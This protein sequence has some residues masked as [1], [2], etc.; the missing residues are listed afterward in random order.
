[1]Q[2]RVRKGKSAAS[3]MSR[4]SAVNSRQYTVNTELHTVVYKQK[5][6]HI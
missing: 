1:M 4:T 2:K 3:K 6:V 5:F